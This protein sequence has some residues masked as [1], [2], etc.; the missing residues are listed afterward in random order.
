MANKLILDSEEERSHEIEDMNNT[1]LT[2][3][4]PKVKIP[5]G[6][7]IVGASDREDKWPKLVKDPCLQIVQY[8]TPTMVL[9]KGNIVDTEK[10]IIEHY[11]FL[12]VQAEKERE[13]TKDELRSSQPPHLVSALDKKSQLMK[14]VVI[15][16]PIDGD[17]QTKK[18]TE[19]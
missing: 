12:N 4:D 11:K 7:Q 1:A 15:Q 17:P 18:V 10:T 3:V 8:P 16:P 6:N 19:F 9:A 5:I 2:L 13:I 14:T